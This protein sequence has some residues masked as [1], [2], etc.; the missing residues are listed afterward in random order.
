MVHQ[1]RV[2]ITAH[3]GCGDAPDNTMA[4]F[5]EGAVSGADM[6]EVDIRSTKDDFAILLHDD[7]PLLQAHTYEQLNIQDVRRKLDPVYE[8]YEIPLLD[9]ILKV[10][11]AYEITLNLDIKDRMS[12]EPALQ[13]IYR[14]QAQDR[15]YITGCSDGITKLNS[16]IRVF[17]NTPD[18]LS[19]EAQDEMSFAHDICVRAREEGYYGLNMDYR[20]CRNEI[21]D[22]AHENGLAICVY[23]VN[24]PLDMAKFLDLKVDAITTKNVDTLLK[25]RSRYEL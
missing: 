16:G 17:L 6:V 3:T 12:I 1:S 24:H 20:T 7:S 22:I 13:S 18:E 4:S 21:V 23:T 5:L 14:L 10:S 8:H 15:V 11:E 9:E 19:V 2:L 25:I